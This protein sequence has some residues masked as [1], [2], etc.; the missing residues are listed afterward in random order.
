MIIIFTHKI[1]NKN[2]YKFIARPNTWY[3]EGTEAVLDQ[4]GGIEHNYTSAFFRGLH[5]GFDDG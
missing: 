5:E 1:I 2:G 4:Q 3:D